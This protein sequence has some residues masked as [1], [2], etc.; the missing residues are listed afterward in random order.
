V[1]ERG[2]TLVELLLVITIIGVLVALN[3]SAITGVKRRANEALCRVYKNQ[4]KAFYYG[5]DGDGNPPSHT[6]KTFMR[7][8]TIISKKC[9]ECHPSVP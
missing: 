5:D 6:Q 8:H 3:L 7:R 1:R 4:M 9:W 2:Y